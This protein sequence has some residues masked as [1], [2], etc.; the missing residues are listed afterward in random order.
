MNRE[1]RLTLKWINLNFGN[2]S[3]CP[4][5]N[6]WWIIILARKS[7]FHIIIVW[8][9]WYQPTTNIIFSYIKNKIPRQGHLYISLNHVSFY[10]YMLG[11][12]TKRSIRFTELE[13]LSRYGNTIYLKTNNK[14]Q[15]NFTILFDHMEAY[16]LI[17][18]LNKMA[19]QRII[20]VPPLQPLAR[21]LNHHV[22]TY[23]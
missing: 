1:I 20:Q 4:K 12:E 15:Y 6:S 9:E 16:E 7:E 22:Y 5:K 23:N 11:Q 13:E 18:Q 8:K 14:M 3:I 19:I 21:H 2:I 10:S 17:E